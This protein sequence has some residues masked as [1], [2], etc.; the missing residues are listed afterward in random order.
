M[1]RIED[2]HCS[3]CGYDLS[4]L[5]D[6]SRCPE[7]GQSFDVKSREGVVD[8]RYSQRR[9]ELILRRVRTIS[10]CVA[11]ALVVT[12]A[13]LVSLTK[14]SPTK[15]LMVGAVL[16][17]VCVLAAATSYMYEKDDD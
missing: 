2:L 8:H 1:P 4:G 14:K 10:L 6:K 13:G 9:A 11:A 3:N 17:V 16:A 15:A 12:C 7:C 5:P